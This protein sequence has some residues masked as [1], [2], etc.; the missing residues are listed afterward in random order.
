MG[1]RGLYTFL[2]KYAP[3]V[4]FQ[5]LCT[6]SNRKYGLDISQIIFKYKGDHEKILEYIHMFEKSNQKILC[7]FDGKSEE[8]KQDEME[9]RN[10]MRE[11]KTKDAQKIK[12]LLEKYEG[13]LSYQERK[14]LEEKYKLYSQSGWQLTQ[15]L[16][17]GIK[18]LLYEKYIPLIKSTVEADSLLAQLSQK[19]YLD[20]VISG[21]MD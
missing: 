21:D 6:I 7:V 14:V 19:K 9:R 15:D 4:S 18:R 10:K 13:D 20:F 11:E 16:R 3:V 8:Y 2:K 5:E 1:V 17:H 12:D